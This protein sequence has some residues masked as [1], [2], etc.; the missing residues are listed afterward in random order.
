MHRWQ[1]VLQPGLKKGKWSAEED[2]ILFNWVKSNGANRWSKLSYTLQGRSSKQIRDRWI[3][4]LNPQRAKDFTWTDQLDQILL[5]KYIFINVYT[6]KN[7]NNIKLK[8]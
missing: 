3:N 4:N 1:K 2:Q 8:I 6:I 7:L 5:I